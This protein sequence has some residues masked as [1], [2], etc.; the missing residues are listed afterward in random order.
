MCKSNWYASEFFQN[1]VGVRQGGNLSPILF[2]LI[3][4]D[5]EDFMI[6]AY[7]GLKHIS[8]LAH[9]ALDD[10]D[11]EFYFKLYILLYA[12]NIVIFAES[13]EQL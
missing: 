6:H 10:N 9:Q 4:S 8:D 2:S 1:S 11:V 7:N 13:A 12:D 5:L 3:L